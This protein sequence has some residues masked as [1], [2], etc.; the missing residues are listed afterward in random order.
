MI[1]ICYGTRPEFIKIKPIIDKME[2]I[3]PF[4][5]LFTGQHK[6]IIDDFK[7]DYELTIHNG[8]NR[9][10]SVLTSGMN[11]D[12][13][14]FKDITY[15]LVQGDTTSV[16]SL[17]LSAF[18]RN[19]KV[20]HLEAGLRTYDFDNPYPEE[21]NRQI[22]SRITDIHLCPTELNKTN[23]IE[24]KT[25]G[26]K[27]VVGNTVLDNLLQYK[28]KCVYKNIVLVTLHR[29]ENHDIICDWFQK[30]NKLAIDNKDVEF[31]LPV[32]PNP[33]VNK[34]A[35]LLTNVNVIEPLKHSD[36]LEI[37]VKCKFVISDSGGLQEESSFLNKKIIVCRETTERPEGIETG[38]LHLCPRPDE[39]ITH[40]NK[41][42][43]DFIINQP[44][45]YGDGRSTEKIIK[46]LN[47]I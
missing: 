34:H 32:H 2:G 29:R 38:H 16:L 28:H 47:L 40:F 39:L 20:I 4:K 41:I 7:P 30:I 27:H 17:A 45:P 10:D 5:T 44:C 33:H 21:A 36:L 19:I 23:L 1:L 35:N 15:I 12:E 31:I 9:L 37:L 6:H 24:E 25:K 3:I 46:I 42:N 14:I 13:N 43:N 11:I 22:V 18:H 8:G 26:D